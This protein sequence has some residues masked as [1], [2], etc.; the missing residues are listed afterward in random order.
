MIKPRWVSISSLYS[1]TA[2]MEVI[3]VALLA[4][5]LSHCGGG[6]SFSRTR[7]QPREANP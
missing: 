4:L 7:R 3:A 6:S 1:G 2:Q 5:M